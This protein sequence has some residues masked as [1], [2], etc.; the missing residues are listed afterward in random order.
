MKRFTTKPI[1]RHE[2]SNAQRFAESGMHFSRYA[3]TG[4][5][6][7]L[8]GRDV[9]YEA[10]LESTETHAVYDGEKLVGYLFA[11]FEGDPK[12]KLPRWFS[13][14]HRLFTAV[15][16]LSGMGEADKAYDEANEQMLQKLVYQ[17]DGE[18]TLFAVDPDYAGHGIGTILLDSLAAKHKGKQIYLYTDDSCSYQ[19]YEHRGFALTGKQ[20]IELSGTPMEGQLTC[21]L[22]TKTL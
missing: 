16:N 12:I 10:L 7:H 5:A 4:P 15:M 20:K 17:P 6:L 11:R 3:G 9:V 14:Y 18:I 13:L 2:L 1:G 19:F 8:Y 21:M 22:F